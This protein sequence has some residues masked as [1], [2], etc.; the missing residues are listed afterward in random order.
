VAALIKMKAGNLAQ[1]FWPE[2]CLLSREGLFAPAFCKTFPRRLR[3]IDISLA[4]KE[5]T[6]F[7]KA[8]D[9]APLNSR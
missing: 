3:Q 4:M 9:S 7:L 1:L 2:N 8:S 5:D 6:S